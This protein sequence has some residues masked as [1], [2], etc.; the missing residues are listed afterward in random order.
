MRYGQAMGKTTHGMCYSTTYNSWS[1]MFQRCYNPKAAGWRNYGGR[2][3][4]VCPRWRTFA[5]FLED[6]GARPPGHTLDRIDG[7]KGYSKS[8]CRWATPREQQANTSRT[9]LLEHQGRTQPLNE[10]ARELGMPACTISARLRRGMTVKD[11]LIP[12]AK[13]ISPR[14]H[15]VTFGGRTMCLSDW[16]REIGVTQ[17]QVRA[18]LRNL[19]IEEA[20]RP[21]EGEKKNLKKSITHNGQTK[22]VR[23]W[24]IF[25]GVSPNAMKY[26]LRKWPIEKALSP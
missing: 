5:A 12:S 21:F 17:S 10:W 4:A 6:M 9:L 18:R 11:A 13:E 15:M 14:K 2:G 23:Q 20:L 25:A 26:R 16:A 7:S 22:S 1:G 8:N 19:P 3:I 24:A